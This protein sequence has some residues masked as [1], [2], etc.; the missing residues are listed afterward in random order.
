MKITSNRVL[1]LL[2]TVAVLGGIAF[3]AWNKLV[4]SSQRSLE[5]PGLAASGIADSSQHVSVSIALRDRNAEVT[6]HIQPGWHVNAHPASLEYLIPTTILAGRDGS[7]HEVQA[8]YPPGRSSGIVIDGK[9][10]QV[11]EDGTVIRIPGFASLN[12]DPI[13]VRVQA[14]STRGICLP[15]ANVAASMAGA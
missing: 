13:V 8:K 5:L 6:L 11:Y 3:F 10:I 14:C 2:G 12:G 9:D 7:L 15:P 1:V 4:P